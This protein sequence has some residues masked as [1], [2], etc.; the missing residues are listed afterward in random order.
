MNGK[1]PEERLL[2]G[3]SMFRFAKS[4][5]RASLEQEEKLPP[6]I[7]RQKM[8]LRMYGDEY[9]EEEKNN[10]LEHLRK[11]TTPLP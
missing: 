11:I 10:I 3:A 5:I 8:F 6:N 9:D 7:I 2:M 1:S 4:M